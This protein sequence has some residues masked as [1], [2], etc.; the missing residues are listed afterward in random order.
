MKKDENYTH[1]NTFLDVSDKIGYK[2]MNYG[3]AL[4]KNNKEDYAFLSL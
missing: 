2:N 1:N 4:N 3:A